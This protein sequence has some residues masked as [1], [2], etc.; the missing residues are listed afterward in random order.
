MISTD[1]VLLAPFHPQSSEISYTCFLIPR[2]PSHQLQGDL[3]ERLPQWVQQICA[4]FNWQVEF[5]T[6]NADYF[7]W[8]LQ[9]T[10]STQIDQFM[11][12]IRQKTSELILST[13]EQ[14]RNEN[15]VNDF[16]A[17]GYL[18]VLGTR[19]HPKEMIERY[20]RLS[21]RQ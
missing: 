7:Q 8:G 19:P 1:T 17:P 12:D 11:R 10:P 14:I 13:F 6:V 4:S 5:V 3:A 20:I 15:S 2:L 9:V 16:W 18:V 21:R